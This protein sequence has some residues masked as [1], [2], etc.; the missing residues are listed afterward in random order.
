MEELVC[1]NAIS[2]TAFRTEPKIWEFRQPKP[3][4]RHNTEV[5]FIQHRFPIK[6]GFTQEEALAVMIPRTLEKAAAVLLSYQ[7]S[8]CYIGLK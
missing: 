7:F 1:G 2:I 8:P 3:G 5:R 6:D 4:L